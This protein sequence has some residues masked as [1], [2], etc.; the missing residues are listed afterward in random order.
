MWIFLWIDNFLASS[1]EF[2][3]IPADASSAAEATC[4]S[5]TVPGFSEFESIAISDT[6]TPN[7]TAAL[8]EIIRSILS[9]QRQNRGV[10]ILNNSALGPEPCDRGSDSGEVLSQI[11]VVIQC[12]NVRVDMGRSQPDRRTPV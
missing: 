12:C 4:G 1:N 3:Q 9:K 11:P 5:S 2:S 7:N 10:F 8:T 6:D